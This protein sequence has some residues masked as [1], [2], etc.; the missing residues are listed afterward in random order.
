LRKSN[1]DQIVRLTNKFVVTRARKYVW[2][3]DKSQTHLYS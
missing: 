3:L 1:P 2:A